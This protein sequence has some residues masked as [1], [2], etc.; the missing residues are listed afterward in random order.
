MTDERRTSGPARGNAGHSNPQNALAEMAQNF[1]I[2]YG[3][4]LHW[5]DKTHYTNSYPGREGQT[6]GKNSLAAGHPSHLK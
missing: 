1:S 2:G 6:H 3:V 5:S 4:G